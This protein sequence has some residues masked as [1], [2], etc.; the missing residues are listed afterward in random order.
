MGGV[1]VRSGTRQLPN[2]LVPLDRAS[3]VALSQGWPVPAGSSILSQ[4]HTY[5]A[6]VG[7]VRSLKMARTEAPT[8]SVEAGR[9][10][11]EPFSNLL[12]YVSQ[13]S[14][15]LGALSQVK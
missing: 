8:L 12:E 2:A 6:K 7:C 5:L 9:D 15:H 11:P 13:R 1:C 14:W 10:A 4:T 3:G